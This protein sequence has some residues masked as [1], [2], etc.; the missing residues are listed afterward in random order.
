[1]VNRKQ[2]IAVHWSING[3]ETR[4]V[5]HGFIFLSFGLCRS[6]LYCIN[7]GHEN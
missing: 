6:P 4:M 7:S 2:V 1:M 3:N 5:Q